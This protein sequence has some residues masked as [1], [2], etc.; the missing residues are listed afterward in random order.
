MIVMDV[1][2]EYLSVLRRCSALIA[3][4]GATITSHVATIAR[5]VGL[6]ALVGALNASKIFKEG[7]LVEVNATEGY[8]RAVA[9][10]PS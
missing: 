6:P 1:L 8:A 7:E 4:G 5:E 9:S 3:D 10:L 2:P